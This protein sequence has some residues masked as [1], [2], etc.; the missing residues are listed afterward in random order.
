[1]RTNEEYKLLEYAHK[2]KRYCASRAVCEGCIF[3]QGPGVCHLT[4]PFPPHV[5][6]NPDFA[7]P[8]DDWFY[9]KTEVEDGNN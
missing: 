8:G 6:V 3:R 9:M 4:G 2:I 7:T 5:V 1:M